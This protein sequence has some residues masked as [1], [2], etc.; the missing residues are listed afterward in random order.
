[1][2]TRNDAVHLIGFQHFDVFA[3]LLRIMFTVADDGLVT[4]F[5]ELVFQFVNQFCI[6]NIGNIGENQAD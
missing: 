5:E 3:F 6:E 1:M 4:I 2:T